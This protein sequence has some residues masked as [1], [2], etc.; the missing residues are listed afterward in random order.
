MNK[1]QKALLKDL[2]NDLDLIKS[3]KDKK[4]ILYNLNQLIKNIEYTKKLIN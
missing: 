3:C 2:Q 4:T 1:I